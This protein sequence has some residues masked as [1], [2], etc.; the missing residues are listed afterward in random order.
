MTASPEALARKAITVGGETLE[1]FLGRLGLLGYAAQLHEEELTILDL[2]LASASDLVATEC[3]ALR[4]RDGPAGRRD[5]QIRRQQIP[6]RLRQG[7]STRLVS[8]FG[9]G[10]CVV[11]KFDTLLTIPRASGM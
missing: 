6:R 4:V 2:P 7:Q 8:P 5:P 11:L 10:T 3:Q 1:D 9:Q